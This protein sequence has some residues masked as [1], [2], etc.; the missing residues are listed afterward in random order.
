LLN[1]S[2]I[3]SHRAQ[4]RRRN[5]HQID[6][7]TDHA[8]EHFQ[9]LGDHAIQIENLGGQHLL[10]AE[11]KELARER[12]CPPGGAGDFLRRRAQRWFRSQAV[13]QELRIS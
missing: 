8:R 5:H 13:E 1:L 2:R 11:G 7:F 9:V 3:R 12:R 4:T 10:P 6:I